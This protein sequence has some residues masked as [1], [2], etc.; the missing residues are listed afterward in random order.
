MNTVISN[1]EILMNRSNSY[2]SEGGGLRKGKGDGKAGHRK[3]KKKL[4][5][6][7]TLADSSV[8]AITVRMRKTISPWQ[9]Y[10]LWRIF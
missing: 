3:S 10:F 9:P 2:F 8:V 5:A 4:T 1:F 6:R 7:W